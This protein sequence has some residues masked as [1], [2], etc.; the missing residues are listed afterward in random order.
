MAQR[1]KVVFLDDLDGSDADQTMTFSLDG[2]WYEIDL[3]SEN[4]R[5]LRE[6]LAPFTAKAR[7]PKDKE[8]DKEKAVVVVA[9]PRQRPRP[10]SGPGRPRRLTVTKPATDS[11]PVDPSLVDHSPT[12]PRPVRPS[13]VKASPI[14]PSSAKPSPEKASPAANTAPVPAADAPPVADDSTAAARFE[15]PAPL[16]SNPD[17]HVATRPVAPPKPQT[18]GL[19][20]RS[21]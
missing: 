10:A 2:Q 18:A 6:A 7:K 15:V 17:E 14:K 20:S 16:F 12:D 5:R 9:T 8:K 4:L 1:L 21:G 19:F 3:S 11:N 13:P